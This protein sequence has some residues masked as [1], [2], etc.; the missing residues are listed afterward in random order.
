MTLRRLRLQSEE[1]TT[2]LENGGRNSM[3]IE[4]RCT[5]RHLTFW[6]ARKAEACSGTLRTV[7]LRG[8][9]RNPQ[10]TDS[11]WL[12]VTRRLSAFA[13]LLPDT[14]TGFLRCSN[15]VHREKK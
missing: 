8:T 14:H 15:W 2:H 3:P 4:L 6:T 11:S 9:V 10:V 7:G 1:L 13:K 12:R 5:N